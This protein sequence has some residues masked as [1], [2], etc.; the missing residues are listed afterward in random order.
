[1]KLNE[2]KLSE[3]LRLNASYLQKLLLLPRIHISL[4]ELPMLLLPTQK[5]KTGPLTRLIVPFY[6]MWIHHGVISILEE[7]II[8]TNTGDRM[9]DKEEVNS[10]VL[11][12]VTVMIVM[13][14]AL[15]T[16]K[17]TVESGSL[18]VKKKIK[19]TLNIALVVVLAKGVKLITIIEI[20]I[21]M[22]IIVV[23]IILV[24][25]TILQE[26]DLATLKENGR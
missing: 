4:Q 24:V 2:Y 15:I 18:V 6:Q 11:M 22:A 25:L 17:I 20:L 12:I 21:S 19:E 13:I 10:L 8:M 7:L 23:S 5:A 14:I 26:P 3:M 1:M 16:L 9:H